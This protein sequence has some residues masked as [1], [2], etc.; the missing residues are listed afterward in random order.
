MAYTSQNVKKGEPV[1]G[2]CEGSRGARYY[3]TTDAEG[4]ISCTCPD[5]MQGRSARG[6]PV[7]DRVCKHLR[8][9]L[10]GDYTSFTPRPKAGSALSVADEIK[11]ELEATEKMLL[12][13][14]S[15]GA[16]T[17]AITRLS[18]VRAKAQAFQDL[19]EAQIQDVQSRLQ[20]AEAAARD[21]L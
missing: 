18:D 9:I 20:G 3:V 7:R 4:C 21:R 6:T 8:L 16:I 11:R 14:S 2:E 15:P 1:F 19:L 13:A 17:T 12:T 10:S 5:F